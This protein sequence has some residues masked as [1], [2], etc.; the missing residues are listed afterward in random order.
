MIAPAWP[1]RLP[2]GAVRPAMNAAIGTPRR[3]SP[4]QAAASSSADAADLADQHDRVGLGVGREELEHV[5]ERGADDRVAA[6]PDARRLAD[7]RV[8]HR[9]DGLVGQRPRA[10]DDADAPLAVDGARD[11]AHF[12]PTRR[13]R[14]GAVRA[15]QPAPAA[16]TTSTT[17]TMSSA[18]MPSVM[19][20]IVAIPAATAS[21]TA[22][23][24]PAAGT[25]MHDVLA[26]VSRDRL[27]D[28]VEDRDPPVER[29]LA[30]LARRHA[31]NE[32]GC[33]T[34]ASRA[35]GTRPRGP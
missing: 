15:D 27:R 5:E 1:I 31:G 24:A 23:G 33:R 11:D 19:Q 3:C 16:R 26:P 8:G 7:A 25:K 14:A 29:R 28:R 32:S 35:S 22:S 6:D 9:L 20:K 4:A 21:S 34:R 13:C 17:G 12:R 10:R 18:G 30:A 2:S